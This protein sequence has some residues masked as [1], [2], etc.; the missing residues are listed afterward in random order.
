MSAC[1][2]LDGSPK[3][4]VARFQAIAPISPAKTMVVVT[5]SASTMPLPT[6]AATFSEMNAPTKFRI[7][8]KSDGDARGHRARGDRGGHDVRGVVEAVREVEG[9]CGPDHDHED[10]VAV[11]RAR[12]VRRS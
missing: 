10:D 3:Y 6:V 2:E 7:A 5:A 12:P 4:H 1:D 11:H 9:Q 8:A